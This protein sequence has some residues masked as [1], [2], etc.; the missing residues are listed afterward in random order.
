MKIDYFWKRLDNRI[1]SYNANFLLTHARTHTHPHTHI[2]T[3]PYS[4]THIHTYIHTYK[5]THTYIVELPA[6]RLYGF[7]LVNISSMQVPRDHVS[8]ALPYSI[9]S[10]TSGDLNT[11]TH[12]YRSLYYGAYLSL[13]RGLD[14]QVLTHKP[15]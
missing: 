3:H 13:F 6:L 4:H 1:K 15:A 9:P 14:T 8:I 2:H 5:H 12:H 10:I 7:V 11:N